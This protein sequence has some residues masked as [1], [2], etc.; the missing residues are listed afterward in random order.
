MN[1]FVCGWW[2]WKCEWGGDGNNEDQYL[3]LSLGPLSRPQGP[4]ARRPSHR[5]PGKVSRPHHAY[6]QAAPRCKCWPFRSSICTPGKGQCH[7]SSVK[8]IYVTQCSSGFKDELMLSPVGVVVWQRV[9]D[10]G[11]GH[12]QEGPRQV[13]DAAEGQNKEGRAERDSLFIQNLESRGKTSR[14]WIVAIL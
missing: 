8:L 10:V 12:Q 5:A 9:G 2:T 11:S 7:V 3:F 6:S 13:Y 4:V 14:K 1:W